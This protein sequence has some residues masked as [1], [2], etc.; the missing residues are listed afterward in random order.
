[1][2]HRSRD[3]VSLQEPETEMAFIGTMLA[4]PETI[5][6]YIDQLNPEM[7]TDGAC[8]A[9]LLA[10]KMAYDNG[11][12]S[13]HSI[14]ANLPEINGGKKDIQSMYL[15]LMD[16]AAPAEGLEGMKRVLVDRWCRRKA[17]AVS[18]AVSDDSSA[19]GVEPI[20][21]AAQF[22]TV[23]DEILSMRSEKDSGTFDES[24][25][26]YIGVLESGDRIRQYTTGLTQLDEKIGG[27][28]PGQLYIIAG[29]PAMGKSA[30]GLSSLTKTAKDGH[31]VL[32]FSMEMP[33]DEVVARM[34]A[35]NY[36]EVYSPFYGKIM[37]R[38]LS[39]S[40]IDE[41]KIVRDSMAGLPLYLDY[42]ASHT[43]DDISSEARRLKAKLESEGKTLD[44]ICVDHLTTISPAERYRGNPV[45]EVTQNVEGL[46]RLAKQLNVAVVCLCQLSRD[47]EKRD[48]KRPMLADL[49]W[50]GEIEQA[51]HVVAFVFREEYYLKNDPNADANDLMRVKDKMELLIRKNRQGETGDIQLYC[52]MGHSRVRDKRNG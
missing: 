33:R 11:G 49:R 2:L 37:N 51:A 23:A 18:R 52:D 6:A 28:R 27:Y 7:F 1:M 24:V 42:T 39:K 32:F 31:S 35:D 46:R 26:E 17:F 21:M 8:R 36:E 5:P 40:Q 4:F 41:L 45:M 14:V 13:R 3:K 48:D 15:S 44:V 34:L 19:Y 38:S 25:D 20:D 30:F 16:T 47:V 29:R 9:F 43:I 50:T 12:V 22:L 10:I